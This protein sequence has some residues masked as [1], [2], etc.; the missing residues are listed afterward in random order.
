MS[1]TISPCGKYRYVL[2]RRWGSAQPLVWIMLNPST[3]DASVDDP[4]IRRCCGFARDWGCGGID[5]YN[6]YAYR[7][8]NPKE[9]LRCAD[10]VG[11]ENDYWIR[12]IE[13]DL[14]VV[15]AW[16]NNAKPARVKQVVDLLNNRELQCLGTTASG[17]PKHPLYIAGNTVPT[18]WS[19]P[20]G[21]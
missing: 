17:N 7:A 16:G 1:A 6:L 18:S 10:P 12:N 15:V 2:S 19:L 4:T 9:L 8:T 20:L 13:Q 3:A 5:V 11:A 14:R 21:S